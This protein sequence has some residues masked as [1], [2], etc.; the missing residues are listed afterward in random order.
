[1]KLPAWLD[2]RYTLTMTAIG[3]VAGA[4]LGCI[5]MLEA[6][7]PAEKTAALIRD[8]KKARDAAATGC[9]LYRAGVALGE[10][11]PEPVVTA[12]CDE[13]FPIPKGGV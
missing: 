12:A 10:V 1:V 2:V 13:A 3:V 5:S 9:A 6:K 11:K 8:A 7:T 4:A